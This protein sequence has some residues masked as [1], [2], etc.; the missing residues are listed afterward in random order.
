MT[1]TTGIT[2]R[3]SNFP[4]SK[5]KL[6]VSICWPKNLGTSALTI[7]ITLHRFTHV[8]VVSGQCRAKQILCKNK[9]TDHSPL[10]DAILNH[11]DKHGSSMNYISI[12]HQK[13]KLNL[14]ISKKLRK[15]NVEGPTRKI[16]YLTSVVK[17]QACIMM[18]VNNNDDDRE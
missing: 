10:V 3:A 4:P 17:Q 14:F 5:W 2:E 18:I 12:V 7:A 16:W 8:R 1:P 15:L 6:S 13:G 11:L 9:T